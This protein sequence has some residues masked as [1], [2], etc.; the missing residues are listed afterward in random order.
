M[1][2]GSIRDV[3]VGLHIPEEWKRIL[4]AL[5][6]L[7]QEEFE[8]SQPAI[9]RLAGVQE[10]SVPSAMRHFVSCGVLEV[11]RLQYGATPKAHRLHVEK[12]AGIAQHEVFTPCSPRVAEPEAVPSLAFTVTVPGR[13]TM[14]RWLALVSDRQ[15]SSREIGA[16]AYAATV[17]ATDLGVQLGTMQTSSGAT[18]ST[19]PVQFLVAL[20]KE[21][22]ISDEAGKLI[23]RMMGGAQ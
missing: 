15:L 23:A 18:V 16:I 9:A 20:D 5:C 14:R 12:V 11:T 22:Q 3:V 2:A 4:V 6:D 7:G 17:K 8:L 21:R 10:E 1:S 13:I 19:Y